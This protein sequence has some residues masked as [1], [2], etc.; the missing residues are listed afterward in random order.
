MP[1]E[2][3][4][5]LFFEWV[6]TVALFYL[7]AF[8][9]SISREKSSYPRWNDCAQFRRLAEFKT[10]FSI[11]QFAYLK[12]LL[13]VHG[14]WNYNR[15]AKC[16]LFSFYKN[17]CL[18]LNQVRRQFWLAFKQRCAAQAFALRGRYFLNSF[19]S[20]TFWA[21]SSILTPAPR[22]MVLLPEIFTRWSFY[23]FK[24]TSTL[25]NLNAT[26]SIWIAS[27]VW[28][29]WQR[30]NRRWGKKVKTVRTFRTVQLIIAVRWYSRNLF[31]VFCD[32][33]HRLRSAANFPGT[34]I[35]GDKNRGPTVFLFRFTTCLM[36]VTRIA[37]IEFT[38]FFFVPADHS[39][40]CLKVN[41]VFQIQD[42]SL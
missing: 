4:C 36:W 42:I 20:L 5:Y 7:L 15:V 26:V 16:I 19:V 21:L 25:R 30:G 40:S 18:Y 32:G 13:L 37:I 3:V 11:F 6:V 27:C 31:H 33:C 34:E 22:L 41:S 8:C 10:I 9:K 39:P 17:I 38:G 28:A 29:E 14:A 24:T 23:F 12:K 35:R 2:R 1:V